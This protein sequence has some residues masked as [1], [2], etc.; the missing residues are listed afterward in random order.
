MCAIH[1]HV[2]GVFGFISRPVPLVMV[3]SICLHAIYADEEF[4]KSSV[5]GKAII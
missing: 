5:K 2:L 4:G 1:S 3:L